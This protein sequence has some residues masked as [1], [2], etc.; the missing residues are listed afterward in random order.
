MKIIG[1]PEIPQP[2]HKQTVDKQIVIDTNPYRTRVAL[3]EDGK[4]VELHIEQR[5]NDMLVGNIYKGRVSNVLPGMEAAFVDISEDKNAFLYVGDKQNEQLPGGAVLPKQKNPHV[6]PD[7]K[8]GQEIMVQIVKEPHGTKGARV[9]TQIYLPGHLLVFLPMVDFIGIS[10]RITNEA[11]RA[12][13][14]GIIEKCNPPGTGA[15]VRTAA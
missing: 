13:L 8:P 11:E 1:E 10:K 14:R 7:V 3:L 6:C 9:S 4:T 12:R 15:I 2:V 5:S